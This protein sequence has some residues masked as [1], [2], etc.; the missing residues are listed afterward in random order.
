[1]D[2]APTITAIVRTAL[3]ETLALLLPVCCA[4]CGEPDVQLC[5][6][7]TAALA[8]RP[9]R[10]VIRMGEVDVPVWSG[11]AFEG[12]A[13]RV[14]RAL[15]EEGRTPLAVHLAPALAAAAGRLG[16]GVFVAMP[17]SRAGFRRRGYRVP[18]MVA[19][20]AGM[21]LTALLRPVRRVGDQRGLGR[22]DR[23]RNVAQSLGSLPAS[24]RRVVVVDDVVTTGASL[25]EAF[26]ALRDA[27]SV[28]V[29]AVT[30]AATPRRMNVGLPTGD[31]FQ[32]HR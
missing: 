18:D 25:E 19:A 7:C 11:L 3:A 24:G 1:M 10:Q 27:G 26:R 28:V 20:R 4:G 16:P 12:V 9:Q 31:A 32:T 22:E 17:T 29:G 14:I 15:K 13:A 23:R 8:P 5:E 30:I 6:S 21:P 2:A